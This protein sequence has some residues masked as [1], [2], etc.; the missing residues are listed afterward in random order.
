MAGTFHRSNV[1]AKRYSTKEVQYFLC[2]RNAQHM[3]ESSSWSVSSSFE[4]EL[5]GSTRKC[6]FL[7]IG[8]EADRFHSDEMG[9]PGM[10]QMHFRIEAAGF[11]LGLYFILFPLSSSSI[12]LCLHIPRAHASTVP[13]SCYFPLPCLRAFSSCSQVPAVISQ[14]KSAKCNFLYSLKKKNSL[15][16]GYLL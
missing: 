6:I 14:L 4:Q 8:G 12:E 2:Q 16:A 5:R 3:S 13:F 11:L 10:W 7:F 1:H 9:H 15:S